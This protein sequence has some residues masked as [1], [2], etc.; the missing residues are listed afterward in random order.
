MKAMMDSNAFYTFVA[1][2]MVPQLSFDLVESSLRMKAVNF[3]VRLVKG[4]SNV[5]LVL[6]SWHGTY[7]LTVIPL[8]N[9]DV[10]LGMDFML[11][12]K[13]SVIPYLGGIF[14]GDER[15]PT[16]VAGEFIDGQTGT[17]KNIGCYR[18]C[19]SKTNYSARR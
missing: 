18:L 13:P 19:N 7:N 15:N 2:K 8:N 11:G 9:F 4:A 5:S 16:F 14:I 1:K 10:I 12:A 6:G 17:T 3:E